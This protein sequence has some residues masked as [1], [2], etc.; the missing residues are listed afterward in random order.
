MVSASNGWKKVK[1]YDEWEKGRNIIKLNENTFKT[2]I[3]KRGKFQVKILIPSKSLRA[4]YK[5]FTNRTTAQNYIEKLMK[6]N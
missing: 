6:Y 3:K 4:E 1:G 2:D 5:G